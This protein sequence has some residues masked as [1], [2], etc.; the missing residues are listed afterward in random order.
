MAQETSQG[1]RPIL[2]LEFLSILYVGLGIGTIVF[3]V[4]ITCNLYGKK[5]KKINHTSRKLH[6]DEGT[7]RL[8]E[9]VSKTTLKLCGGVPIV[10]SP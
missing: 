5:K 10:I 7:Q 1:A 2:D 8:E 9:P 3:V 6:F 4:E